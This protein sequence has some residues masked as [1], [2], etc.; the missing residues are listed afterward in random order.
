MTDTKESGSTLSGGYSQDQQRKMSDR[1]CELRNAQLELRVNLS[2][3]S[4]QLTQQRAKTFS[5]EAMGRRLPV[6]ERAVLNIFNI[7]PPSRREFLTKS[8]CT[9]VDIQLHAFAINV[10]AIFDNAAWICM[11]EAGGN[12][13]PVKVG[14][15]KRECQEFLPPELVQYIEQPT[16]KQW[17]NEYGKVYRDSTAHRIPPYLPD[18]NYTTNESSSWQQLHSESMAVL[19]DLHSGRTMEQLNERLAKHKQLEQEKQKLGSNSLLV[20][21]TLSGEDAT[22]PMFLHPQ[23][24]CDWGLVHEFVQAFIKAMRRHYNWETPIIPPMQ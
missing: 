19:L 16:I 18:R 7:Y 1:M 23:L 12:L 17:F 9:D 20:A 3:L 14:L 4:G 11:L 10:Y 5:N 6:I 13:S 2:H 15:F 22:H 21:L 8:E 24:L